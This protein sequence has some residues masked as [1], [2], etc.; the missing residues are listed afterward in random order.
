MDIDNWSSLIF[1]TKHN[2]YLSDV[3]DASYLKNA[4]DFST[5]KMV[6]LSLFTDGVSIYKS[7]KTTL[8]P[9]YL[10]ILNLHPSIRTLAKNIII[11][12]LWIGST[13]PPVNQLFKPITEMLDHLSSTGVKIELPYNRT[14]I[15]KARLVLGIFDLPAKAAVLCC[16]QFNGEYGCTVCL[17]PGNYMSRRRVYPPLAY[18]SRTHEQNKSLARKAIRL[19]KVIKGIKGKSPLEQYVDLVNCI[20]IDY[21]H[22]VLE[23]TVD[24]LMKLWFDSQ[25]HRK[26]YYLGNA[27]KE[28]DKLMMSQTPPNEFKRSP[29]SI[30]SH[31][32]YWTANELKQWL[33]YYSLPILQSRLPAVYWHHYAL[34][35]G[36]IHI[37]LKDKI[38]ASE[39]EATEIMITDFCIMFERLYGRVNC[40][41]NIHLLTHLTKYVRLWGPLW[42]HSAFSCE[43]KNGLL[44]NLFHGKNDISKQ[45]LFNLN[46]Q[47]TVQTLMYDIKVHDGELVV[48]YIYKDHQKSNMQLLDNHVYAVGKTTLLTLTREEEDALQHLR[49]TSAQ[50]FCRLLKEG[51]LYHSTAYSRHDSN[52][53]NNTYCQ[54]LCQEDGNLHFGQIQQFLLIP[55]PF[56]L[57]KEIDNTSS[58]LGEQV[59]YADYQRLRKHQRINLI[60]A[61]IQSAFLTERIKAV[62]I[63]NIFKKAAIIEVGV[64]RYISVLP[65]LYEY[66]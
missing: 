32:K 1:K 56:A 8:W 43:H 38:S 17:H 66:H 63:K 46:G 18:R 49:Y 47:S 58:Y 36:A 51:V 12:G 11:A 44:K 39:L 53:R 40:T 6:A 57:I 29:R 34:L 7:A 9:V 5:Q 25:N 42:T 33:L 26:A 22:C 21:M 27:V 64:N 35:V 41:H 14:V 23:G 62:Q 48:D 28:I 10:T 45:L 31:R 30:S 61:I 59:G 13:K 19:R 20:P 24:R 2:P 4:C 37:L 54:F 60:G 65:N 52:K 50:G 16:K 15:I 3:W 55:E